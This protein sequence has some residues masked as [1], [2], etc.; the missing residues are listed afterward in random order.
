M[1]DILVVNRPR[2]GIEKTLPEVLLVAHIYL[3]MA[4]SMGTI[5]AVRITRGVSHSRLHRN[6]ALSKV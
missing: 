1:K 5:H 4:L 3:Y 2:Q 6:V